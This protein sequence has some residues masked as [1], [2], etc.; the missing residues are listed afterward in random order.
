MIERVQSEASQSMAKKTMDA[1]VV[2]PCERQFT[3][4]GIS[5]KMFWLNEKHPQ[6]LDN[7]KSFKSV[8]EKI[9]PETARTEDEEGRY[10]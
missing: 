8:V 3:C 9:P 4:C 6:R 2:V 1:V 10:L 7:F 5:D